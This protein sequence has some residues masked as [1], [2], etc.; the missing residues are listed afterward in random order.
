VD[1]GAT[2]KGLGTEGFHAVSF[3]GRENAGWAVGES[4]RIAKLVGRVP[5]EQRSFL[6]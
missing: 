6:K 3:A 2:W 1:N 4:G 5:D